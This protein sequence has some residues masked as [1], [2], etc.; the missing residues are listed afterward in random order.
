MGK[1]WGYGIDYVA[2]L[3]SDEAAVERYAMDGDPR[4]FEKVAKGE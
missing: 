4:W 1:G 2:A 3:A